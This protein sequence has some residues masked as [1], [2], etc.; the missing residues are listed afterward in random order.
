M[1]YQIRRVDYFY[2]MVQDVPG[3]AYDLLARL[4]GMGVNLVAFAAIPVGP[5]RTQLTL[6]PDDTSVLREAAGRGTMELDGPHPALLVQGDDKLGALA[7]VHHKLTQANVNVYA[8]TGVVDGRGT[9]GYVIYVRP[10][11]IDTAIAAFT[12]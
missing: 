8:S 11:S 5:Q 6:F 12:E 10:D 3:A 4:A 9:Y 2:T 1:S 7:E